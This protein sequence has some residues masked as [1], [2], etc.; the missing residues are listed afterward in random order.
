VAGITKASKKALAQAERLP[1]ADQELI[2]K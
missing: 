2:G 1:E